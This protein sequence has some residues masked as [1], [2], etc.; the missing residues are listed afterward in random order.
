MTL[1]KV[2][3]ITDPDD[4]EMA[5]ELSAWALGM[6]FWPR[7]PR[8]CSIEAAE[9]IGVTLRRRAE[10]AGVFVDA[11]LDEVVR[12]ADRAHLGLLQ[13]HGDEGPAYCREAGRRTGCRVIKAARVRD[14]GSLTALEP[15]RVDF[16][17]LD[18]WVPGLPGGTGKTVDWAL[19]SASRRRA[20]V[21]L[22]G[23]LDADNVAEAIRTVRPYAVDTASGTESRPGRKDPARLTAFFRAVE[24]IDAELSPPPREEPELEPL[25]EPEPERAEPPRTEPAP[26]IQVLA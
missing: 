9:L 22:S 24:A 4:A 3:G 11:H 5:V 12:V 19:V 17:L 21:I 10:L 16:H 26:E 20:P 6:I 13:F 8:A 14:A 15:Y 25:A 1:V 23:G 2:C 18:A 7:S